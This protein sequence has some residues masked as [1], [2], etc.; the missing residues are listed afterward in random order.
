MN[1]KVLLVFF[2]LLASIPEGVCQLKSGFDAKEYLNI[3]GIFA[4]S[5]KDS[6]FSKGIPEPNDVKMIYESPTVGLQNKWYLWV[7]ES[8]KTVI[9][10]IRGT[11]PDPNSW[12]ENF[13]AAM[14]PAKGQIKLNPNY[15]FDYEFSEDP[16][17]AVHVG[18]TL[19]TGALMETILPK[20]DG[21]MREG[22]DNVLITGHSQ[23]GAIGYLVSSYLHTLQRENRWGKKVQIKTILSAAPKPGNLFFAYD[24]ERM[25]QGGW[26]FN[27]VNAADW[28]PEVPFSIQTVNDFSTT[29]PFSDV[30]GFIKSQKFP[31]NLIFKKVYNKLNK[32][33]KK[34]QKNFEKYLGKYAG[35]EVVKQLPAFEHPDFYQSNHYTRTGNFVIL[36]P[37]QEYNQTYIYAPEKLFQHHMLQPYLM[38][39]KKQFP[40]L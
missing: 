31:K 34:A 22:Y 3:L 25:N 8:E 13:Y 23:G 16:K 30:S 32:P 20:L 39:L 19:A 2:I 17:A 26:A 38:L 37:D 4:Y 27:V 7:N 24:Y 40:E 18:W 33:T 36:Y 11:I 5:G 35:K 15:T 14:I 6:V 28:V 29:N 9:I 21:L 1:K 12:L 10:N